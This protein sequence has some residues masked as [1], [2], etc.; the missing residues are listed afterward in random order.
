[1]TNT[2]YSFVSLIYFP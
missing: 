1:M 2:V